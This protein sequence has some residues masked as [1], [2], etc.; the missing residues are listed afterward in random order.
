[1]KIISSSSKGN[2]IYEK[3][4]CKVL[5]LIFS[6]WFSNK[7]YFSYKNKKINIE[8]NNFWKNKFKISED[9]NEKGA[10][11]FNF[12]NNISIQFTGESSKDQIFEMKCKGFWKSRY[13]IQESPLALIS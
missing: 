11:N 8:A 2:F 10:I 6:G 13:E 7:A 1:M 9:E 3:N 12:K 5:E 4:N